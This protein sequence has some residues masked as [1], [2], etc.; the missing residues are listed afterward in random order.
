[1]ASLTVNVTRGREAARPLSR[2][3][4]RNLKF[5]FGRALADSGM[6]AFGRL[7]L[8]AAVRS[9]QRR[10]PANH[11]ALAPVVAI[12]VAN[13]R[14]SAQGSECRHCEDAAHSLVPRAGERHIDRRAVG[15]GRNAIEARGIIVKPPVFAA[16][17]ASGRH[18]ATVLTH[19]NDRVVASIGDVKVR[20]LI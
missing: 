16:P 14:P 17:D 6:V 7:G 15:G 18:D 2:L 3:P 19:A 10:T 1:M 11:P 8:K 20:A 13:A 12:G 9:A 4:Q 5:D